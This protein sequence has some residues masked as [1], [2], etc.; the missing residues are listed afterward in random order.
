VGTLFGLA[1]SGVYLAIDVTTNAVRSYR[2]I[3]PLPINNELLKGGL[4]SAALAVSLHCPGVT[5]HSAL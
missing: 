3:S 4:L 2:T 1:L 5:W